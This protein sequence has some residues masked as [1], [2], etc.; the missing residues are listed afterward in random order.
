MKTNTAIASTAFAIAAL[1]SGASHAADSL[2]DQIQQTRLAVHNASPVAD[3]AD[4]EA[5]FI[6]LNAAEGLQRAGNA[7]KA[8]QFL[9][10]AR[11]K[12]G[13]D[14]ASFHAAAPVL[15]KPAVA[16][17]GKTGSFEQ[18]LAEARIA[19]HS[20]YRD[21]RETATINLNVAQSLNAQGKQAAAQQYLDVAR[22][23]LGLASQPRTEFADIGEIGGLP[24]DAH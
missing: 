12:L 21:S 17:A 10:F 6:S 22:G 14:G 8:Q 5:A 11:A 13:L 20:V 24:V 2:Q 9:S 23:Q 19:S 4:R 18:Q 7:A 3:R 1:T 16:S 15:A